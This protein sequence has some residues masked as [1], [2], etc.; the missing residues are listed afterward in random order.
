MRPL[1]TSAKRRSSAV[2]APTRDACRLP[3]VRSRG[4]AGLALLGAGALGACALGT[5]RDY[6]A[7]GAI[8]T[9]VIEPSK[10]G[11]PP[12]E[13]SEPP[14]DVGTPLPAFVVEEDSRPREGATTG[15]LVAFTR[16]KL[17]AIAADPRILEHWAR[18]AFVGGESQST[19]RARVVCGSFEGAPSLWI[20]P[21]YEDAPLSCALDG[22]GHAIYFE[23]PG[24]VH[25]DGWDLYSFGPDG[26]DD[27]CS[28]DDVSVG[29]RLEEPPRAPGDRP[30]G[31][32][33]VY[34]PRRR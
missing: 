25:R 30:R 9:R 26:I 31:L 18:W 20:V 19:L 11:E 22:W 29:K 4:R 23:A 12:P 7:R 8:T 28:G 15:E 16:K 14:L 2:R 3:D 27:R 10:V 6:P 13:S 5:A 17:E 34:R 33:D 21:T 24:P 32:L 1:S